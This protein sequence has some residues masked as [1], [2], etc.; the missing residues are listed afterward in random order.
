M[1]NLPSKVAT[2]GAMNGAPG[3]VRPLEARDSVIGALALWYPADANAE[4]R[5]DLA[6]AVMPTVALALHRSLTHA[7]LLD[8]QQHLERRVEQRTGELSAAMRA[9]EEAEQTRTRI[10]ANVNHEIRTPLTL[11]LLSIEELRRN[12]SFDVAQDRSL[13][14]IARNSRKLLRLVDG[15]LLLAAGDEQE[16]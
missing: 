1:H 4:E 7:E 9:L 8:A 11:V 5:A 16:A 12:S 13:A 2:S 14:A 10:F 15:L 3:L 6:D